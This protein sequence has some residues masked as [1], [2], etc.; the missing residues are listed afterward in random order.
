MYTSKDTLLSLEQVCEKLHISKATGR[1]WIRLHK[2]PVDSWIEKKPFFSSTKISKLEQDLWDGSN[3]LLKS[4]RN[5]GFRS[6]TSLYQKYQTSKEAEAEI[7]ATLFGYRQAMEKRAD[8]AFSHTLLCACLLEC[9][10]Q[11]YEKK[12]HLV[13]KD[14][15]GLLSTYLEHPENFQLPA[16]FPFS[17]LAQKKD[18]LSYTK[19]FPDLFSVCY[20]YRK[21]EDLL[22]LLY[23]S[24]RAL[25][26]RKKTGAYYTPATITE[27][28]T[29]DLY[30][31]VSKN[32]TFLDPSC[33]TG[34][35]LLSLAKQIPISQLY[36]CD[37]D[38]ISVAITRFNLSLAT[39]SKED[40]LLLSHITVSDFL[41]DTLP[42]SQYD[43]IVGNPPWG[44]AFTKE[45]ETKLSNMYTCTKVG[46]PESYVLFM[47]RA[48]SLLSP[49][50]ILCFVL[51]EAFLQ[52]KKHTSIRKL[53]CRQCTLLSL[54][55]LGNAF[56]GV[57]C[58]SVIFTIKRLEQE[59]EEGVLSC[60]SAHIQTEHTQFTI[61]TKRT[62]TCDNFSIRT[63]DK[64]YQIL[65]KIEQVPNHTTLL[66]QAEFALGIV[67][68]N[69]KTMLSDTKEKGMEPILSGK[70][71]LPYEILPAKK[72]TVFSKEQF[73]QSAPLSLY[74]A[75]QKFVY[76]FI[77]KHPIV[78][79]DKDGYL[80]LN[81]C[82]FFIPHIPEVDMHYL[83][84]VLNSSV[85]RFYYEN[86]FHS[87]KVLRSH[88]EQ[89][90][91]PVPA[92]N[93][94]KSIGALV[95]HAEQTTDKE[96]KELLLKEIDSHMQALYGLTKKECHML[97]L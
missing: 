77:A 9:S 67:T 30:P 2:L 18:L 34:S 69:N 87:L 63:D 29:K 23:Q 74:H 31:L 39:D 43:C 24:I 58:P 62:I 76:R 78:A 37:I 56:F 41:L 17:F 3:E 7:E 75:P 81:S 36:G 10:I 45:E 47:E 22:G 72:Y 25:Q 46:R 73:Q 26:E 53:V 1:N 13:S 42:V 48:L 4:R 14:A 70:E 28:T 52:A 61:E 44:T 49:K 60:V 19:Q 5:K 20:H 35:F 16:A 66:G 50:G 79:L 68:G 51:P 71:I 97:K 91:I 12:E 11:L 85:I 92:A 65:Q 54:E 94:Q 93:I 21:E 95:R 32:G 15:S 55:Y 59:G 64:A 84:A 40:E 89:L 57:Q 38:A 33:G 83:L 90:P 96:K 86:T 6:G 88:L 80:T 27:K 82:N 8:A